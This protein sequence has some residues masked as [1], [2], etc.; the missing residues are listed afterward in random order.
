MNFIA[1]DWMDKDNTT[2]A[3]SSDNNPPTLPNDCPKVK[4]N[5]IFIN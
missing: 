5:Y 2:T 1:E 3:V 4:T